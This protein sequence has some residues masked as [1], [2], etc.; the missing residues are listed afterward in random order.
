VDARQDLTGAIIVVT[1]ASSGLGASAAASRAARGAELAVVG[2]NP[3]RTTA[4]AKAIGGTAFLADFDHL[5]R[6]HR[7]AADLLARYDRIDVLANNAG[8]LVK[9]RAITS[10]GF[11]RTFQANH[12]A[13]FLLTNLLL[14]VL[15]KSR[16]RV[17]STASVANRIGRIALDDLNF[18]RRAWLGGWPA[19]GTSK[20]MDILFTEELARR[21]GLE[22]YSFHPGYVS[23]GFGAD[24]ALI[25]LANAVS[26]GRIGLR[27][28]QGAAPLVHLASVREVGA[29][30]GTHFDRLRP[31]GRVRRLPQHAEL[32]RLLWEKSAELVGLR[33]ANE[34]PG[35]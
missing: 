4:V 17:I 27:P 30:S 28:E 10:D 16:A 5:D 13:P 33:P 11:E 2:R 12:L 9:K 20:L 19:Y 1:G 22:A 7:L 29:P 25:R 23:T 34:Q 31:H 8:G 35:T 21:T 26:A 3:E 32:A 6:V 24:T 15:E 18:D 14:P